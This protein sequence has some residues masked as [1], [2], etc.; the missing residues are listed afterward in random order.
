MVLIPGIIQLGA[1]SDDALAKTK[2]PTTLKPTIS[3]ATNDLKQENDDM[4]NAIQILPNKHYPRLPHRVLTT[5]VQGLW[6]FLLLCFFFLSVSKSVA[7]VPAGSAE[8]ATN[9]YQRLTQTLGFSTPAQIFQTTI[10]DVATY[11]GYTGFTGA[12]LQNLPSESLMKPEGLLVPSS[13]SNFLGNGFRHPDVI[14]AGLGANPIGPDDI[15]VTRFFAPKIMNMNEAQATRKN[16]W[17]K[18]VRLRARPGS[19]AASHHIAYAVILFN[20]FT[21]PNAVPFSPT[22]ESVNTQIILAAE[23]ANVAPPNGDG[24]DSIYWLDYGPLSKGGLL[25]LALN[26][27][28]D[29]SE[30]PQ[31]ST[32]ARPYFVPDGCVACH[33]GNKRA[34]LVNYLDTDHWFDR[35]E[36]DPE[37]A[38]LKASGLPLLVDAKTN[39]TDTL[40]YKL[41]FD[42]IRRFNAQA[43]DEV[44]NTQ[45]AHD[46]TLASHKWLEVHA[47]NNDHVLPIDRAIGLDPRWSNQN[48]NDAKTL[49]ALNQYCFRCHGSVKFSVFNRQEL[50]SVQLKGIIQQVIQTNAT[51][52][53]KMPPDRT[54]PDEQRTLILNFIHQH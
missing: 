7:D 50:L 30:L 35:L 54:L 33:G 14:Q 12:D 19:A 29:A 22:D 41:A 4:K 15:L 43:D 23:T 45:P 5:Q 44:I 49:D 48:A 1:S 52:G 13:G 47:T 25:S 3:I 34:A 2:N 9:Y 8:D 10:D 39:A 11:M 51:V 37:F 40:A 24:L 32:G 27:F 46:E 53:V 17:R 38:T 6:L 20:I 42:V 18:L 28:F 26:A 16:G 31:G 36:N 21:A